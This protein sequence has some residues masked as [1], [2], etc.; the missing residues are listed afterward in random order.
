[1]CET[2]QH[3]FRVFTVTP[4]YENEISG[5]LTNVLFKWSMLVQQSFDNKCN[6]FWKLLNNKVIM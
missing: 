2:C 1:M 4:A 5:F 6:H 3:N